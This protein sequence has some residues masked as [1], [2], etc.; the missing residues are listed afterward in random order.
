MFNILYDRLP[1]NLETHR[2]SWQEARTLLIELETNEDNKLYWEH[3]LKAM[4]DMYNDLALLKS[5]GC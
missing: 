4:Q 3:E 1:D 5:E 2:H